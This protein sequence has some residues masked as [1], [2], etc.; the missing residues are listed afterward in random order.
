MYFAPMWIFCCLCFGAC[1]T[2][3]L[4]IFSPKIKGRYLIR[5]TAFILCVA[6]ILAF[7]YCRKVFG[8]AGCVYLICVASFTDIG[9]YCIGKAFRGPKLCP[10]IS[11]N[12]TWA[13]FF[14]GIF[15]ANLACYCL[16]NLFMQAPKSMEFFSRIVNNFTVV[17]FV[18][19]ASV[20]GDLLESYFK[21]RIGV[22]D[23]GT[24]FPGHGGMLD[25]LDSLIFASILLAM[26]NIFSVYL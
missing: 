15:L 13:G 14:G 21:R 9:A 11:P 7:I 24:L 19:M 6:G 3:A 1:A 2:I 5:C 8:I 10:Q 25:R 12:K 4:E 20:V 26:I 17:Q 16:S 23:M 18:I 22:K